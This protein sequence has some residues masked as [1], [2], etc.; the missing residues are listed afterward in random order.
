MK[1][2]YFITSLN[3]GGAEIG[4]ARLING[5][6]ESDTVNEFDITVIS[7]VKTSRDVVE[8]LPDSVTIHHL[9]IDKPYK[10]WKAKPLWNELRDTDVL[11]CSLYHASV[12]GV[13]FGS[14]RRVPQIL[15]WQ[16]NSE[17]R[18]PTAR[19][20]YGFC[21]RFSD[22][23]LADSEA[24]KKLLQSAYGISSSKIYVLPIAGVDTTVF[25]P[26]REEFTFNNDKEIQI[27]T[28]GSLTEQKGYH[29]LI[30]CADEVESAHFHIIGSGA[31]E[32]E[33]KG[34]VVQQDINNVSFHGKVPY[35]ELPKYLSSF[36]IYF[37]PSKY[38]G[39]CIT[40]IEAMAT[41]LP[42]VASR[43]GGIKESIVDGK[44]GCLA[45]PGD[46]EA[47]IQCISDL[48]N[49]DRIRTKYGQ[50]SR[51]RVEKKYSKRI[52]RDKFMNIVL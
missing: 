39:L 12:L 4:M 45:T 15:T 20:L 9:D 26:E 1:I 46:I 31:L 49:N 23:I 34:R 40:V 33:L 3:F 22:S 25:S 21:Y 11:V 48:G 43:T 29:Y 42:I 5:I 44:N 32:S 36:D 16:H 41:G 7:L 47:Y 52:L 8:L 24:V 6:K 37:Q 13:L 18:S 35:E 19:R 28:V 27:G 10:I 14:L 30:D 17:Y 51:Y 2:T 38:E 50:K